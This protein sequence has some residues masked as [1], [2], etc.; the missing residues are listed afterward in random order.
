MRICFVKNTYFQCRLPANR[1]VIGSSVFFM[2]FKKAWIKINAFSMKHIKI[3]VKTEFKVKRQYI[4]ATWRLTFSLDCFQLL[5]F[6]SCLFWARDYIL[7]NRFIS[8]TNTGFWKFWRIKSMNTYASKRSISID[9]L[10]QFKNKLDIT[11]V[12]FWV[13]SFVRQNHKNTG[14]LKEKDRHFYF[15]RYS[16]VPYLTSNC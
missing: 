4:M 16:R 2:E 3:F 9:I 11:N 8:L 5:H 14:K 1:S 6:V 10:H 12:S 15:I 7:F 13:G